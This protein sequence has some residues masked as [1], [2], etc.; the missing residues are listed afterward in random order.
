MK[1]LECLLAFIKV[2]RVS[3]LKVGWAET[4]LCKFLTFELKNLCIFYVFLVTT[5]VV[6]ES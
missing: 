5:R 4:F 6:V 1:F 2:V 3:G